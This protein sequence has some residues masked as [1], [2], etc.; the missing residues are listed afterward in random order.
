MSLRADGDCQSTKSK[1]SKRK[2]LRL[3]LSHTNKPTMV[4][5]ILFCVE[6]ELFTKEKVKTLGRLYFNT[7][8]ILDVKKALKM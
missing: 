2:T 4:S 1:D 8:K 5:L 7:V 3:D 6:K